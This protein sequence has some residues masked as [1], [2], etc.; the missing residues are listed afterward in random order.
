[1]ECAKEMGCK[2]SIVDFVMPLGTTVNMNGTALYEATTVIFL[3]QVCQ[4]CCR[5]APA[6]SLHDRNTPAVQS[7]RTSVSFH[8]LIESAGLSRGIQCPSLST[9]QGYIPCSSAGTWRCSWIWQHL[10]YSIDSHS[11]CNR[12]CSHSIRRASHHV[13]GPPGGWSASC[14]HISLLTLLNGNR[15]NLIRTLS[16]VRKA[17]TSQMSPATRAVCHLQ[18][19][20][21]RKS[22]HCCYVNAGCVT[23]SLRCGLGCHIGPG[24]AIRSLSDGHQ[25]AGGCLWGGFD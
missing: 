19:L 10:R 15:M 2:G 6:T 11:G 23:G 21:R 17:H 14:M 9:W 8:K 4:I 16:S 20:H 24:L 25:L 22:C 7:Q 3:A 5:S 1:M 12:G 13:D 18:N